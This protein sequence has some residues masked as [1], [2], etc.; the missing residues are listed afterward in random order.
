LPI[1]VADFLHR[2]AVRTELVGD[3]DICA[4]MA[5]HGF[6]QE[7][8]GCLAITALCDEDFQDLPVE[9]HSPQR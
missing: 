9:I 4:T 2:R 5:F 3:E 8:L 6:P 7:F 1:S